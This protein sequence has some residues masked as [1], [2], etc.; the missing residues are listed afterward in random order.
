MDNQ[1]EKYIGVIEDPRSDKE[2]AKDFKQEELFMGAPEPKWEKRKPKTYQIFNQD[3]SLS[4]VANAVSK[5]LGI[6]EI[7]EGRV[8]VDLSRRDIYVRR[9]NAPGGGMYLPNAL[10]IAKDHGA[11]LEADVPSENKGETAMNSWDGISPITDAVALKYRARGYVELPIDIDAIAGV[12]SQ[13]K[14]VLLGFRFQ[15]SEWTNVPKVDPNSKKDCGHGVAGTDNILGDKDV[16]VK[17]VDGR[18]Y[19]VIEDSWG[20]N[21]AKHGQRFIDEEFLKARCFYAGY[22]LNFVIEAEPPVVPKPKHKFTV[23]LHRGNKNAD[24]VALQKILK[25]EGMFPKNVDS[26]GLYGAITQRGVK[27]FQIK[28]LGEHNDGVQVGPKTLAKLNEKYSQ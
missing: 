8:W 21:H 15:Y 4:C 16:E 3:G 27:A 25:Y 23:I 22:T 24:V 11:C 26:T 18:K 12:L 7:Y 6:D 28:Y 19:I 9:A 13:G 10:Q 20:P 17:L 14:G 2:K 5:I 1:E